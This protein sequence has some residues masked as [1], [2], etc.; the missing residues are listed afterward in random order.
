[1]A[2]KLQVT[3]PLANE[4]PGAL[5]Y[6]IKPMTSVAMGKIYVR[7]DKLIEAG[8]TGP[9]PAEMTFTAEVR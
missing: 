7:K 8:H 4:T 9:W 1:M 6:E 3:L 2:I 5:V